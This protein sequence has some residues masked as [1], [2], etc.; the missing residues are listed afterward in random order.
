DALDQIRR[1]G[2]LVWGGDQEGGGPYVFPSPDDP[3]KLAGFEVELADMLAAELGVKAR[4]QQ[5]Q[6]ET[7]PQLLDGRIDLALNGFE[8]TETRLRDY[9]CTRPYYAFGLQLIV[10]RD[11]PIQSWQ[12]LLAKPD[13]GAWKI[14]VLGASQ[15]D[16]YLTS[17][18]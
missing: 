18:A 4:F 10:Q 15:A 16:T 11:S 13:G 5:G 1:R 12:Q 8:R 17:L 7:L 3:E 2:V 6:W 9:G 14:G